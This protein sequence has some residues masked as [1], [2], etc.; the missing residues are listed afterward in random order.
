MKSNNSGRLQ[1]FA[2]R[3]ENARKKAGLTQTQAASRLGITQPHLSKIENGQIR[4][5]IFQL[6][7]FARAYGLDPSYFLASGPGSEIPPESSSASARR[8]IA[9]SSP[10][11]IVLLDLHGKCVY[12]NEMSSSVFGCLP[13]QLVG[14]KLSSFL[15]G[16]SA[17]GFDSRLS[18]CVGGGPVATETYLRRADGSIIAVEIQVMPYSEGGSATTGYSCTIRDKTAAKEAEMKDRRRLQAERLLSDISRSFVKVRYDYFSTEVETALSRISEFMGARESCL[19]FASPDF[20]DIAKT[21]VHSF[22]RSSHCGLAGNSKEILQLMPWLMARVKKNVPLF[23]HDISALPAQAQGEKKVWAKAGLKG[24][25]VIPVCVLR[26]VR[27]TLCIGFDFVQ[28]PPS[29]EETDLLLRLADAFSNL[30]SRLQQCSLS[31]ERMQAMQLALKNSCDTVTIRELDGTIKY[32]SRQD[33]FSV[34]SEIAVGA[35]PE[36]IFSPG[37]LRELRRRL[38]EAVNSGRECAADYKAIIDGTPYGIH[39][40]YAPLRNQDGTIVSIVAQERVDEP[41]RASQKEQEAAS[42]LLTLLNLSRN[43][44]D[45]LRSAAMLFREVASS[46]T[47]GLRIAEGRDFPFV[48]HC[49]YTREFVHAENSVFGDNADAGALSECVCGTV[50][51]SPPSGA[52]RRFFSSHGTFWTNN[53]SEAAV[54]LA[55]DGRPLRPACLGMGIK[56]LAVLPLK[57]GGRRMGAVHIGSFAEGLFS[58]GSIKLLERLADHLAV[59]L[60]NFHS[61]RQMEEA[62]SL[63][64]KANEAKNHFIAHLSHEIR[65]YASS[66]D[67][68]SGLLEETQL[69]PQQK[70]YSAILRE[71]AGAI[72]ALLGDVMDVSLIEAGRLSLAEGDLDI[73]T[74]CVHLASTVQPSLSKKPGLALLV[75]CAP[76]LPKK[77]LGDA[78][79]IRQI[80]LNLLTNAVK[81]THKGEIHLDVSVRER[82]PDGKCL[83]AVV[84]ADT[85]IGI[86]HEHLED[87]FEDFIRVSG[88][89]SSRG[90]GC[91]IGL[92]L[93]RRLARLMGGDVTV[94]SEPG[95]G[96]VFTATLLLPEI[97]E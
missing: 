82:F 60:D 58:A 21:Y 16:D 33:Y 36:N 34:P 6:G 22:T 50:L 27:A 83:V 19:H 73:K 71:S 70:E 61:R 88:D 74:L 91:G 92:F 47:A 37:T 86:A 32:C 17:K 69:S 79:R 3:L 63:A 28:A 41:C 93:S 53:L 5:D 68:V 65:N 80:V 12:A 38:A 55:Q 56:S 81:Y 39:G 72:S 94:E 18:S 87:I 20:S 31:H 76:D 77:V 45:T 49:G 62:R 48:V 8:D 67:S 30:F 7:A 95:K 2:R 4:L 52:M 64:E 97:R 57:S 96:S 9:D 59:W 75:S 43:Y 1:E 35:P 14:K 51:S 90:G 40:V 78:S 66:M 44:K 46:D 84:L 10:H 13:G 11:L 54:M 26:N 89:S 85:G 42:N 15:R 23:A 25:Y 29:S 24:I